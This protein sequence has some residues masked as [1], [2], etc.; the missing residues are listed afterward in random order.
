M[1][2]AL[3]FVFLVD[4]SRG[5]QP[6]IDFLARNIEEA[7]WQSLIKSDRTQLNWRGKVVGFRDLARDGEDWFE[8]NVFVRDCDRL[9]SQLEELASHG[10]G[11]D[12]NSL[13]D[14]IQR[15]AEMDATPSGSTP[16]DPEKWRFKRDA[17]R[18]VVILTASG[19]HETMRLPAH[20][21]SG[22]KVVAEQCGRS[23]LL[24]YILAPAMPCYDDLSAIRRAEYV[25]VCNEG[26]DAVEALNRLVMEDGPKG[27]LFNYLLPALSGE[28]WDPDLE[29]LL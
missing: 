2:F 25:R 12:A 21:G 1:T 7:M 20:G 11:D 8:D 19:F 27:P 6:C 13:L 23:R 26:E 29:V 5:M 24:L 10:G 18:V 9:R 22:L 15:V 16:D 28:P 3:D 4:A 14:A 17:G